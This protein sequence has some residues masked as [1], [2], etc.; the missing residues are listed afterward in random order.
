M[1]EDFKKNLELT[2]NNKASLTNINPR[3]LNQSVAT[4]TK[5]AL[6]L[7]KYLDPFMDWLFGI[8]LSLAI[9][10]DVL[11]FVGVGSLPAIGTAVTF[12]VSFAIGLIMFITGSRGAKKAVRGALKRFGVLAGGTGIELFFGLNF[13]PIE[14]AVVVIVFYMTLRERAVS[15]KDEKSSENLPPSMSYADDYKKESQPLAKA[16]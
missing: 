5:M 7:W 13:F 15:A 9:I 3:K 10:K 2:R 12:C 1:E 11:D 16:A 14:S 6:S 4:E 8:A